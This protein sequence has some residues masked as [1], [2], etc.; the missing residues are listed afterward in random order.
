M[1]LA[2]TLCIRGLRPLKQGVP[3][4]EFVM[5]LSAKNFVSVPS[6]SNNNLISFHMM[7]WGSV[8][9]Y[10]PHSILGGGGSKF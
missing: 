10:V 5:A 4:D 2:I 1:F 8:N 3:V 6:D 9:I 7:K